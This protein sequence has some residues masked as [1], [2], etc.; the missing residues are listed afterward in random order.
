MN[1]ENRIKLNEFQDSYNDIYKEVFNEKTQSII[2]K[3]SKTT[4][5]SKIQKLWGSIAFLILL[6]L[7]AG[8]YFTIRKPSKIKITPELKE[9]NFLKTKLRNQDIKII[10]ILAQVADVNN[11]INAQFNEVKNQ[12]EKLQLELVNIKQQFL[13]TESRPL[14]VNQVPQ[15]N[16]EKEIKINN[17]IKKEKVAQVAK[18]IIKPKRKIISKIVKKKS[19]PVMNFDNIPPELRAEM[20]L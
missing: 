14:A 6:F 12:N 18:P 5:K 3:N 20:G 13:I 10:A 9:I 15:I 7:I 11:N 17:T 16:N 8:V 19:K 2:L 1:G 4:L